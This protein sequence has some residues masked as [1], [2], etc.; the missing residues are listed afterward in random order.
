MRSLPVQCGTIRI[1]SVAGELRHVGVSGPAK[2]RL[3]WLFRNFSILDFPVLNN[4]QQQLIAQMWQAGAS[5]NAEDAPQDL[6]GSIDGFLPQLIQV[7]LPDQ[8]PVPALSAARQLPSFRLS[9]GMA[10]AA[11]LTAMAVLLLGIAIV[12]GTNYGRTPQPRAEAAAPPDHVSPPVPPVPLLARTSAEP[13]LARISAE[14]APSAVSLPVEP[15]KASA[16]ARPGAMAEDAALTN[17]KPPNVIAATRPKAPGKPEVMIRVSVDSAGR[18]Q[19]F[20]IL[21]GD[22]TKTSAAL[23]AAKHWPFQPCSTSAVCEHTLKF[24]EYGDSSSVKMID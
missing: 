17:A 10:N 18:A 19:S 14:P 12:L 6:I 15:A 5:A 4:K 1:T 24:T 21:S 11:A 23:N 7:P 8:P 13:A 16:A 2:T 20:Q 3:L 22:H 9:R